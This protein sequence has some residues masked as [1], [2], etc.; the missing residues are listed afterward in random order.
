MRFLLPLL[1]IACGPSQSAK[2]AA[3]AGAYLAEHMR[4][5]EAYDTKEAI[6][7]CRAQVRTRWGIVV[8]SHDAGADQ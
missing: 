2:E 1:L 6:D 8:T 5:V 7:T 3:A 4:C